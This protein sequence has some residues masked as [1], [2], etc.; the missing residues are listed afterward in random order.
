MTSSD[1]GKIVTLPSKSMLVAPI[2][3]TDA[4]VTRFLTVSYTQ[5][6]QVLEQ[7]TNM[8]YSYIN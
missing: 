8:L 4:A 2:L 6:I 3:L 1:T 7:D 5:T